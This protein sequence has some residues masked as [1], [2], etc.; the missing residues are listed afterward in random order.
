MQQ[1]NKPR[2]T[3]EVSKAVGARQV[4]LTG[5]ATRVRL[6][7]N[8]CV[9]CLADCPCQAHAA[10]HIIKALDTSVLQ[11]RS[12]G[13]CGWI[14]CLCGEVWESIDEWVQLHT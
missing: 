11:G 2:V 1:V 10:T 14:C 3:V 13:P 8:I 7:C 6:L 12:K 5:Y 9:S 4:I